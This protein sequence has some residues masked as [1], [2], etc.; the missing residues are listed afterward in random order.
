MESI[1][2]FMLYDIDDLTFN[3]TKLLQQMNAAENM[4][5]DVYYLGYSISGIY[6][7]SLKNEKKEFICKIKYVKRN[8]L[9]RMQIFRAMLLVLKNYSFD[10]CYTRKMITTVNYGRCLKKLKQKGIKLTVEVPTYPDYEEFKKERRK[11][12][13]IAFKILKFI[14][15]YYSKYVDLFVL[16][17]EKSNSYFGVKAI[18]IQNGISIDCIKEWEPRFLKENELHFIALANFCYW[19]GYERV[20]EGLYNYYKDNSSNKRKIYIHF[21]GPDEDGSLACWRELGKKKGIENHLIFE[22]KKYGNDLDSIFDTCNCAIGTL[23][24]YKKGI[25]TDSSLKSLNYI[26][27]GIPFI[28]AGITYESEDIAPYLFKIKNDNTPINFE[29][30]INYLNQLPDNLQITRKLRT[31]CENNCSWEKQLGKVMIELN[32]VTKT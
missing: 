10:Y 32:K 15:M 24:C 31:Y 13:K 26:A 29:M 22:G 17:G 6:L 18:N 30:V 23:G 14:D 28:H 7:C 3:N 8:F 1:I 27:R 16:I 21:V 12:R 2:F 19:H 5:L 20:I 25:V 4:G 11:F 9:K